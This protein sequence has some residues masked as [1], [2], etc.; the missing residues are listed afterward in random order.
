LAEIAAEAPDVVLVANDPAS[1]SHALRNRVERRSTEI[2]SVRARFGL[3]HWVGEMRS[4]Y[5]A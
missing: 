4:L 2:E 3:D 5:A 1:L